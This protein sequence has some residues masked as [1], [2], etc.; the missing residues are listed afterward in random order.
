MKKQSIIL[1]LVAVIGLAA[2][3]FGQNYSN[4]PT[5]SIHGYITPGGLMD[6]VFDNFGN[7]YG[8]RDIKIDSVKTRNGMM[9]KSKK[10]C[11]G[12][13]FNLYF[14]D[15]SGME[16]TSM[17]ETVRRNVICQVFTDISAFIISPLS[18]PINPYKV[19]IWIRDINQIVTNPI[20][21]GVSGVSTP[22]YNVPFNYVNS[23]GGI[24]DNEVWKTIHAGIDSY[25]GVLPPIISGI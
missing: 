16:D 24:A 23:N 19:N 15:G 4:I 22:F 17:Q 1:V 2:H 6:T 7:K 11:T 3:S 14:E 25:I 18:N 20:F 10:L 9:T 21:Y 13:Y 5:D 8:L 12:G